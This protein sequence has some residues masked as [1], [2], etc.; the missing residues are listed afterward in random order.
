MAELLGIGKR[1]AILAPLGVRFREC[2]V[3]EVGRFSKDGIRFEVLDRDLTK[4]GDWS[5]A[6]NLAPGC[7]KR[8]NRADSRP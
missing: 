2:L 1:F 6:V 5:G 4:A 8:R 7:G 3:P